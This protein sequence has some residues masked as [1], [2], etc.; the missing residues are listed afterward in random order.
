MVIDK[1][2]KGLVKEDYRY[3]F[4]G[5][6]HRPRTSIQKSYKSYKNYKSYN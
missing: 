3:V 2:F 1:K 5:N 6:I 4:N